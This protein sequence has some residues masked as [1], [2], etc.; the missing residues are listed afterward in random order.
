MVLMEDSVTNRI[1]ESFATTTPWAASNTDFDRLAASYVVLPIISAITI[2]R[3]DTG[4][5]AASCQVGGMCLF[6]NSDR[7]FSKSVSD[8]HR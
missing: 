5:S 7:A 2:G 6:S 3:C 4:L 1:V 8:L